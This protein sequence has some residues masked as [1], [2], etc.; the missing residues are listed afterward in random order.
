[1]RTAD[2][3]HRF[4]HA[5]VRTPPLSAVDGLRAVDHGAP[6]VP[7]MREHHAHYVDVLRSLGLTV[8]ML[9][10]EEAFPDS[11][12]V[13]DA[14][15]CLPEGAVVLR[16]GAATRVSEA[17]LIE[18]ALRR[19]YADVRRIGGPGTVDGGDVLVTGSEIVVGRSV[20]TD[21]EGVEELRAI[22][23]D[24]GHRVRE[25]VTPPGVLHLKTHCS[26]PRRS[27]RPRCSP[28]RGASTATASSRSTRRRSQRRTASA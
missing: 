20:R 15:L 24:W 17:D 2:H 18:P 22:V 14:A 9:G 8:E 28:G 13:E 7:R 11:L 10:P 23:A 3:S 26:M 21:A 25:V 19:H 1:M 16:P 5:I 27:S 4:T 12:F 6:D